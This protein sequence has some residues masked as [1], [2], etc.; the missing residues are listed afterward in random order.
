MAKLGPASESWA[1]DV[2][3]QLSS[4]LMYEH[5]A[6]SSQPGKYY[7]LPPTLSIVSLH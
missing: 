1:K 7:V 4:N 3:K 2:E 6:Q 5:W